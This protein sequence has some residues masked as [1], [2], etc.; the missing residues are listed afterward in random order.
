MF[1]AGTVATSRNEGINKHVKTNLNQKAS[2]RK[3]VKEVNKRAQ[4]QA[5][6]TSHRDFLT[7]LNTKEMAGAA[8]RCFP[9]IFAAIKNACS[10]Y[11]L[12][13]FCFQ[14]SLG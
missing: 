8:N 1:T 4:Y 6:T 10:A 9:L 7:V 5:A 11:A 3:V 13:N 12:G 2:L 14:A